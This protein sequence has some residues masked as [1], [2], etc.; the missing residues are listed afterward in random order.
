M[1]GGIVGSSRTRNKGGGVAILFRGA[2]KDDFKCH[3]S[4]EKEAEVIPQTS[5]RRKVTIISAYI[6]TTTIIKGSNDD[7]LRVAS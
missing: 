6:T 3:S 5:F 2:A 4:A 1:G 7:L